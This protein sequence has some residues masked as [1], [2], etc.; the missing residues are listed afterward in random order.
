[1]NKFNFA[2]KEIDISSIER[3]PENPRGAY[4]REKDPNFEYL[5]RSIKTF[6]LLVPLVVQK[7]RSEKFRLIDGERR[8][9][10]LRELGIRRAP[11]HVIENDVPSGEVKNVM[12]H[13]HTT[14][15][16]WD[17][18]EQCR[19]LEPLYKDLS[20]HYEGDENKIAKD[21]VR[22]T[23]TTTRTVTAR[24]NFLLQRGQQSFLDLTL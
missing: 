11:A 6:G 12:F 13:I 7:I 17:A 14:R 22:L 8:Y 2:L 16:A 3:N 5:K 23:G 4:V 20:S 21:L 19:A 1:M 9:N 24:L 10:A 15:L 18:I